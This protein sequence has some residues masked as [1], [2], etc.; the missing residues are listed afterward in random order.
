[1]I[2]IKNHTISKNSQI[3]FIAE[4]GI[5]HNGSLDNVYK[6]IKECKA[7]GADAVKFQKRT[8][9]VVYT[10]EEL[11]KPRESVFGKTNGDLKRGLE[12]SYDDYKKIDEI[13][14]S[15]NIVWFASCW[16]E[17]SV[18]FINKFNVPCFKI[19]S[20]SLTDKKLLQFTRSKNKPI[21]LSTGMSTTDEIDKAI[22]ILDK[23][24]LVLMHSTS[25]YPCKTEEL[26][27]KV[28]ESFQDKYKDIPIGY[29]GHEVGLSTTLCAAALGATV[30]ERHVTLD[31]SMWGS[32]QSAS[33]EMHGLK[34]LIRDIRVFEKAAGDG[35]KKVYSSEEPII[36]KLRR[37]DTL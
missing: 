29:S 14:N 1:M 22:N 31:R 24:K 16:D 21:L 11:T 4:I 12:F 37:V 23:E 20:A 35:Q 18:D 10:S 6:L 5:N 30:I 27:L 13:C 8:I 28:I 25:S 3:F 7:A 34:N 15:E 19:A 9:D 33:I 36:K 32:D 17:E 26:N 2:K